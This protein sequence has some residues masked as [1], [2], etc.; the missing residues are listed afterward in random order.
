[1]EILS[2]F[3]GVLEKNILHKVHFLRFVSKELGINFVANPLCPKQV[4][5][6]V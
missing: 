1:M 2:K 4:K 5:S 6:K 3:V